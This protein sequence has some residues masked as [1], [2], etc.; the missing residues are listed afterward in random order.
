MK[1]ELFLYVFDHSIM[2]TGQARL[3]AY[4]EGSNRKESG[5]PAAA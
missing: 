3:R 5:A 1:Y 4:L 2:S